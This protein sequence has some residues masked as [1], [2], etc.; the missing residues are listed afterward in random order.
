MS[1]ANRMH[2]LDIDN[3]L[4]FSKKSSISIIDFFRNYGSLMDEITIIEKDDNN[5]IYFVEDNDTVRLAVGLDER[6][7]DRIN[8]TVREIYEIM[9]GVSII[10]VDLSMCNYVVDG[11]QYGFDHFINNKILMRLLHHNGAIISDPEGCF[12]EIGYDQDTGKGRKFFG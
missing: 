1:S 3:A 6:L 7:Y 8:C 10:G 12:V 2:M 5:S 4:D 9:Q 11:R